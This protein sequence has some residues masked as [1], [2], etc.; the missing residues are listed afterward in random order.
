MGGIIT[1]A[2]NYRGAANLTS[3]RGGGYIRLGVLC[4]SKRKT[5]AANCGAVTFTNISAN[6]S[7][8]PGLKR[9]KPW[10]STQKLS[11]PI[12]GDSDELRGRFAACR[13]WLRMVVTARTLSRKLIRCRRP[14][15]AW[16]GI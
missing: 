13:K 5:H 8:K 3:G 4:D 1:G 14:S 2:S 7:V 9:A 11:L 12:R 15:A 16:L 6:V 10:R